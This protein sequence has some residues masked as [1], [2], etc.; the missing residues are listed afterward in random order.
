MITKHFIYGSDPFIRGVV[1]DVNKANSVDMQHRVNTGPMLADSGQQWPGV[2]PMLQV[3]R[4][5][6]VRVK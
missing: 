5:R 6:L 4:R 1:W 3:I 2:G